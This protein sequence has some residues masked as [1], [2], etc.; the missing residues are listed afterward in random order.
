MKTVIHKA[1]TRG[2]AS[3]GWLDTFYTFS[4]AN[5]Y[6]PGR[7]HFGVLRVLNDDTIAG[8]K[9]FD[10]HPHDNMEIVTIP[11][12]GSLEHKDSMGRTEVLVPDEVQVM[13]AGTGIFHSEY[14]HDPA[15]PLKLLQIWVLPKKRNVIPVY[16]QKVFDPSERVNR[17]QTIVSP[18]DDRTLHINQDTWFSRI[19]LEK[20][21][22]TEYPLHHNTNG[23][24]LFVIEGSVKTEDIHLE[25]RDGI[26]ISGMASLAVMSKDDSELL[27]IEI[28]MVI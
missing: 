14:N 13:S 5:Y 15:I 12:A 3:Y 27:L 23:L 24:Y 25:R 8:G 17:W 28:P 10:R 1:N 7:V 2:H 18:G 21:K 16:D 6:D 9:G 20:G 26:G 19:T 22:T 4:F 11:L